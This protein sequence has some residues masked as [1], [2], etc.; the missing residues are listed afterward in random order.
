M[1]SVLLTVAAE[2]VPVHERTAVLL[3]KRD[4]CLTRW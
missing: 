3:R 1:R 2:D 4:A